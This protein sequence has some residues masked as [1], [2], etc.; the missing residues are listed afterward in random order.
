MSESAYRDAARTQPISAW[1]CT[2]HDK[3]TEFFCLNPECNAVVR[4]RAIGSIYAPHFYA[5]NHI[6]WCNTKT[7]HFRKTLYDETQFNLGKNFENLLTHKDSPKQSNKK[8]NTN[9]IFGDGHTRV[10]SKVAQ[11]YSMCK[12]MR[13]NDCYNGREV[14]RILADN[15]CN[16]ILTKGIYGVRLVECLYHRYD[17][18]K[19]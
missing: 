6:G 11:I 19:Q 15:R 18:D 4:L 16:A 14:W 12:T 17:S 3:H 13:H 7:S 10:L 9:V 8:P 1:D 2:I 5:A